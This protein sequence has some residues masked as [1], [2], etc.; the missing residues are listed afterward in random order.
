MTRTDVII[1]GAGPAGLMLAAEL[2]LAGVRPLV[3]ERKPQ[4]RD[5]PKAGGLGGQILELLRYRGLLE[6][7]EVA[8]T[9][10]VPPPRF[11]FGGVH[12]DFTQLADPPLH[13][14]P[15]PQQRLEE[16][17]DD[18]AGELGAEIRR[19][20]EVTGI[21][22]D[23]TAVTVDVLGPDG[24]YQVV[25]RYLVGC[26][27]A[28]SRVRDRAAIPFPGITYPEVNRLAQVTLPDEVTVLG[29]GDL[30]VPGF[31][32]ISAGFTRTDHG[33]FGI[34]SSPGSK[35]VSLYTIEDE[36]TEYDD[37]VPMTVPELQDSIHR[38]L[39]AR[40]PVAEATR[41]SR[42]T[43]KARQAERYRDGRILLAGDAAHLFPATGVALNAGLLDAV[44][45]AWKLAADLHGRAP[46]RLLDTYHGERHLAGARTMLH[47]RA[48]V[49]LRRGRDA[50]AEA[51]REVFTELLTDE[52]PLRRMGALVAGTDVRYPMPGTEPHP[53]A[54]TFAP[55]LVLHTDQGVTSVA[56]LLHAA[57]PVLLDL[58][59]RPELRELA[60]E[61]H[62]RVDVRTAK[63][64]ERPADVLLIRPDAHIAWAAAVGEPDGAAATALRE[65]LSH[66]FGAP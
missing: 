25:G 46:A 62:D 49:A 13:A 43:F 1:V 42:F 7:F 18:R 9:G 35:A 19:G 44:N 65:A 34:G 45:L 54:G 27:G 47:T 48:Q 23:D 59:G 8:C 50:A 56:E 26:D 3:L 55:D 17:L 32:T 22:Q 38:V 66:W 30:D 57:R 4:R 24:P 41:L 31:G 63:T 15:L 36:S 10:P 51:L 61:W 6:R 37:D 29:N 14:L 52:Q 60:R 11:P 39:G 2:R 64:D 28:R 33:L 53:L 58:A 21:S 5:I 40:L 16:L 20:H 12:L